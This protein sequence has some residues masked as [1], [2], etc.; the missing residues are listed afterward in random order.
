MFSKYDYIPAPVQDPNNC[1]PDL[2]DNW[3]PPYG[4]HPSLAA[5]IAFCVLFGLIA[6]GHTLRTLRFRT[7]TAIL[8]AIGALTETIGWAGRT[9]S[10]KCPYNQNAFLM[11]ITTL[12]IGPTFFAA[13]LYVLLGELIVIVGRQSTLLS[14]RMY[15]I[16]FCTCDVIS[17][18]VQAIGGAMASM[19]A[20][21]LDGDTWPGTYTMVAGIGFQLFTM[22]LFLLLVIDF[23]RRSFKLNI[24][25]SYKPILGAVLLSLV[26]IYIRS[27]YRTLE[28]SGGWNGPL[29]KDESL[30]IGLDA[31]LMV[32]AAAVFLAA[33][34]GRVS[35]DRRPQSLKSTEDDGTAMAGF[36]SSPDGRDP[37]VS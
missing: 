23:M 35:R 30:F 10:S 22:T 11:Q 9:W 14:P 5:G 31:T 24:P 37:S 16:V 27:I 20:G 13:A 7:W 28:L 26:C 32:I 36:N 21:E 12:I 6:I 3:L 19:A 17:L 8:L 18:V 25:R 4:F 29:I 34:P 1:H 2:I 15:A 33:D